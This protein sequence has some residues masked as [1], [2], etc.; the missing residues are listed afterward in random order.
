MLRGGGKAL[1]PCPFRRYGL[2]M[3]GVRRFGNRRDCPATPGES[4]MVLETRPRWRPSPRAKS[5]MLWFLV[6]QPHHRSPPAL[7][8]MHLICICAFG[9]QSG[10]FSCRSLRVHKI[11]LMLPL[12]KNRD[13][14]SGGN[15]TGAQIAQRRQLANPGALRNARSTEPATKRA[16]RR[17]TNADGK[18]KV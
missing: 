17:T 5:A 4:A 1:P 9:A 14:L 11:F 16:T 18:T 15:T 13:N 8:H 6:W 2:T 7:R 12:P 10:P 3:T